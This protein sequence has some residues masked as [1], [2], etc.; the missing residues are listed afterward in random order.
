M[1]GTPAKIAGQRIDVGQI[2][3]QRIVDL[4]AD[5]KSRKGRNGRNDRVHISKAR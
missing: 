1:Q 4:L 2:H 3:R 5:F